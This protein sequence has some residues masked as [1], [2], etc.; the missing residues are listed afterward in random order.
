MLGIIIPQKTEVDSRASRF[1]FW[2]RRQSGQNSTDTSGVVVK[3]LERGG[4]QPN[5][6]ESSTDRTG[7]CH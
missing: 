6:L 4:G 7:R 5:D 1:D 3:G 2:E